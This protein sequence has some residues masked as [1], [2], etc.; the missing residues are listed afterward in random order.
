[1]AGKSCRVGA[2]SPCTPALRALGRSELGPER[3]FVHVGEFAG[4]VLGRLAIPVIR[5]VVG[6]GVSVERSFRFAPNRIF[7]DER[8]LALVVGVCL[9][10]DESAF[11]PAVP[12][13]RA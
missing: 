6:E 4:L 2:P 13:R 12:V 3:S 8:Q 7:R 9:A 1:M 10:V 11:A 5:R